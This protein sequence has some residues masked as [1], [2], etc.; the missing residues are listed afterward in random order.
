MRALE[1]RWMCQGRDDMCAPMG[2]F[3]RRIGILLLAGSCASACF[4]PDDRTFSAQ[5]AGGEGDTASE[6]VAPATAAGQSTPANAGTSRASSEGS[7]VVGLAGG[8]AVMTGNGNGNGSGQSAGATSM[9]G[10]T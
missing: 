2:Q 3:D 8:S 10:G 9:A 6:S 7:N 5:G 4:V 1:S